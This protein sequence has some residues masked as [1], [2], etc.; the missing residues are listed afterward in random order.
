MRLS[1]H[2]NITVLEDNTL[3][4]KLTAFLSEKF[5]TSI[6]AQGHFLNLLKA[7]KASRLAEEKLFSEIFSSSQNIPQ[8]DVELS[9]HQ[10]YFRQLNQNDHFVSG[11]S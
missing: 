4:K 8:V 9:F 6:P 10:D 3:E 7:Y 2:K 5:P 11:K 1:V